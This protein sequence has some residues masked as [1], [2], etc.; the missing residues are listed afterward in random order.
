MANWVGNYCGS[1][2]PTTPESTRDSP[3]NRY[4]VAVGSITVTYD[5]ASLIDRHLHSLARLSGLQPI[6]IIG[7]NSADDTY[8]HLER[9]ADDFPALEIPIERSVSNDGFGFANNRMAKGLDTDL[10]LLINPDVFLEDPE[11]LV[12]ALQSFVAARKRSPI[13]CASTAQ[14]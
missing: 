4:K 7:N 9:S 1:P 12:R 14:V 2:G 8:A 6:S 10:L 11:I 3:A 13:A 5:S